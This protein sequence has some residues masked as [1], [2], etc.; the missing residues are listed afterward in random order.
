MADFY[1]KI[2]FENGTMVLR[3]P[4]FL[5]APAPHLRKVR[6]YMS[7]DVEMDEVGKAKE[8]IDFM[9]ERAEEYKFFIK[10][11]EAPIERREKELQIYAKH[12]TASAA[13][14]TGR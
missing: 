3:I 9:E 11:D 7:E 5:P 10:R 4:E 2:K 1:L 14:G 13:R 6:R 8:L 12:R